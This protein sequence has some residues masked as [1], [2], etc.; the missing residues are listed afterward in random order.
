M[1]KEQIIQ[2]LKFIKPILQER[3]GVNELALFGSYSRN[4]ATSSSDIDLLIGFEK[5]S[6][7]SLFSSYDLLQECFSDIHVQIVSKGA[8]KPHYYKAIQGDLIYA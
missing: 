4:E 2:Q 8:I 5:P 6:A 1:N 7:E 3:Y